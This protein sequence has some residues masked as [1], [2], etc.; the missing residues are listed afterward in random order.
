MIVAALYGLRTL[1]ALGFVV[2]VQ[3]K[4]GSML[5]TGLSGIGTLM[6]VALGDEVMLVHGGYYRPLAR[7]LVVA[8]LLLSTALLVAVTIK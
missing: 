6:L 8:Y 3:L 2:S 5:A 4:H 1:A 7:G